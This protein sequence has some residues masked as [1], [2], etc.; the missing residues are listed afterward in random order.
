MPRGVISAHICLLGPRLVCYWL[1]LAVDL[2][3]VGEKVSVMQC[4]VSAPTKVSFFFI[5]VNK[6]DKGSTTIRLHVLYRDEEDM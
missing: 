1:P 3:M 2:A 6:C 4:K 5:I